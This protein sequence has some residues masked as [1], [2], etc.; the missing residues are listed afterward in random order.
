M[1]SL[2][3]AS[4]EIPNPDYIKL[5][6]EFGFS[7][8]ASDIDNC[9]KSLQDCLVKKYNTFDDRQIYELRVVKKIVKKGQ[10]YISFNIF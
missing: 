2:L 3:P 4:I 7:S 10:E 8:K 6:I 9:I 5:D 1:M